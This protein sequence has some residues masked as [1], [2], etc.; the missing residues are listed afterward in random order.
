MARF[1][2][3]FAHDTLLLL[4]EAAYIANPG[5]LKLPA[6]YAVVG[7]ITVDQPRLAALFRA[8]ANPRANLLA[9]VQATANAFGW[10]FQDVQAETVVVAFR[11]TSDL[12]DWKDDF[13]VLPEAYRPVEN[14]GTVHQ[15]FQLVYQ[16]LADS[17]ERLLEAA[18][19]DSKRLILT[20][21]SLGAALSELAAPDILHH[22]GLGVTP[23]VQN[24]AG[25]RV[26]LPDFAKAFSAEIGTCFRV[27][28]EWDIVPQLPPPGLFEHVGTEVKVDGGFT[29]D[30]L[31]AHSMEKSYGPGLL[32]L[33]QAAGA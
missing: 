7:Q 10:V 8:T 16:S 2:P 27:V 20:G 19:L 32:K 26:G 23:E 17:V 9:R 33:I 15:G 21:H 14:Y 1:D 22:S 18:K 5:E 30:E 4:A 3:R 28:N 25:P 13:D 11:G 29:L 31:V 6:N 24:F 12:K